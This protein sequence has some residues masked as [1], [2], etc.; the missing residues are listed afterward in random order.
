MLFF[1]LVLF[2]AIAILGY[3]LTGYDLPEIYDEPAEYLFL[4]TIIIQ[5]MI[6]LGVL[7]AMYRE[8]VGFRTIGFQRPRFLDLLYAVGFILGSN[9]ILRLLQFLL[10]I[11]GFEFTDNAELIARS[12]QGNIW[13]WTAICITAAVCEET[14][15][16]GWL[17]TRIKFATRR[18]WVIP[19]IVASVA[20]GIGHIYQGIGGFVVITVYG[21][22]F[23]I[24]F[25]LTGTLW[26]GILAHF[27]QDFMA[28]FLLQ[29]LEK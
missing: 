13:W 10:Q 29:F 15:F 11:L 8:N 1:L 12:A 22:L 25:V 2:P 26:P 17:M 14:A 24:L 16:R 28:P 20:F 23:C 6:F 3:F 7:L 18:G 21:A 5:W 27:I 9:A 19:T 4:P